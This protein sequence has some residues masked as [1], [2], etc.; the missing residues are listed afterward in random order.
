MHQC[1]YPTWPSLASG[2]NQEFGAPCNAGRPKTTVLPV[3]HDGTWRKTVGA[4]PGAPCSDPETKPKQPAWAGTRKKK[5]LLCTSSAKVA[6]PVERFTRVARVC[7]FDTCACSWRRRA[8]RG[9]TWHQGKTLDKRVCLPN[10]SRLSRRPSNGKMQRYVAR[11][12]S[13]SCKSV[14]ESWPSIHT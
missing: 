8:R 6:R 1:L 7:L 11:C 10:T 3:C 5:S 4:S 2:S 12:Y 13:M 14:E 9:P